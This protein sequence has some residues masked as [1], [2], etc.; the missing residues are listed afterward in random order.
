MYHSLTNRPVYCAVGCLVAWRL[1]TSSSSLWEWKSSGFSFFLSWSVGQVKSGGAS[2]QENPSREPCIGSSSLYSCL[3]II[4]SRQLLSSCVCC[5][6]LPEPG[7][8]LCWRGEGSVH[9]R[10]G[11][12]LSG[13]PGPHGHVKGWVGGLHHPAI[14]SLVLVTVR[15]PGDPL[16]WLAKPDQYLSG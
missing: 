6:T 14:P 13:I 15:G 4:S 11:N 5:P 1:V 3:Y 12:F 7:A 10:T 8:V 2:H 9:I 16:W